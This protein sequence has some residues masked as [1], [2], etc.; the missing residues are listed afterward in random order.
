MTSIEIPDDVVFRSLGEEAVLLHLGTGRYFGLDP[1]ATRM[2]LALADAG[3][4]PG[5]VR[6][7]LDEYDVEAD[8][9][10][11]DLEALIA[12]LAER[13]LLR[14]APPPAAGSSGG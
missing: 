6:R 8:E 11:R 4:L 14:R 7:L 10:R 5:A 12:D 9:L 2:W 3:D 13:R 1:V